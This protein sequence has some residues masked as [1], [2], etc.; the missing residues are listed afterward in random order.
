MTI[1]R[2]THQLLCTT[3]IGSLPA[4]QAPDVGR[5]VQQPKRKKS[6]KYMSL[7]PRMMF[8]GALAATVAEAAF[9]AHDFAGDSTH[10]ATNIDRRLFDALTAAPEDLQPY[11]EHIAPSSGI[12]FID[13]AVEDIDLLIAE[14]GPDIA[15]Y[16]LD[17]NTDGVEQIAA[18]L[19]DRSDVSAIHI[20]SHGRSGT[21]DL[22]SAKLT[23]VSMASGH[24]DEMAIIRGALAENADI[25]I[26]GCDFGAGTRGRDALQAFADVTGADVAASEDLTGAADLGGDWILEDQVGSIEARVLAGMEWS[27]TLSVGNSGPWTTT[28]L[29]TTNTTQ[30]VTATVAFSAVSAQSS[31]VIAGNETFNT[32]TFFAN[33]AD[34]DPSLRFTFTWDTTPEAAT[35]TT[36]PQAVTDGGTATMTITFSQ[37]VT[38]PIINLDRLGG[39][40]SFDPN[41]S[42]A[43]DEVAV[44]NSALFTLTTPGA[45]LTDL[46]VPTNIGHFIVTS[47]TIQRNVESMTYTTTPQ[48][49]AGTSNLVNTAAGSVRVNGTFTSLTFVLS[50]IGPEGGGSDGIEIGLAFDA[51]PVAQND[52]FTMNE[53]ATLTGNLYANNGAGVDADPT[54]DVMTTILVNG[55]AFTVGIPILL[56][57]GSLTITNATTGAFT[58]T[59]NANYVGGQTFTYTI[60]DA[61]GGTDTATA[62]IVV[63]AETDG[64]GIADATDI[65][66]DNDGILDSVEGVA[67]LTAANPTNPNIWWDNDVQI[68]PGAVEQNNIPAFISS[69]TV[70]SFGS[71]ITVTENLDQLNIAGNTATTLADA[72]SGNDYVEFSFTSSATANGYMNSWETFRI[73]GQPYIG[74]N[75]GVMVNGTLVSD[76]AMPTATTNFVE[77]QFNIVPQFEIHPS[78]TYTMRFY[79]YGGVAGRLDSL[80]LN[81]SAARDTDSDG[82]F[83]HLDLDSDNDS[84]SDL[85]ES[86]GGIGDALSDTNL[87][88]TTSLAEAVAAGATGDG[89][90]DNDGLMDIFDANT[91]STTAAASLGNTPLN[92]DGDIRQNYLDLDSDGDGIADTV[93]ARLT[94]GYVANDGN[95]SNDDA[96][97][98]GVINMFD[99]STGFGGTFST[100]V[101]TDG[102][103]TADYLDTNSDNDIFLDSVE[104][105]LSTVTTD[106]N[107]DGIRDSVG[108]SYSDPDGLVN[109]PQTALANA[110]GTTVDVDYRRL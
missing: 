34:A 79:I 50:G 73:I 92:T 13:G 1:G 95:V 2:L 63:L 11:I 90:I 48:A 49:E 40:S 18:I 33:A 6:N 105:G 76:T 85:S 39:Q 7:E 29:S 69:G 30:G 106:A 16:V 15:I 70:V 52:A 10:D 102:T 23:E 38:N 55:A 78:T 21:L 101:N 46:A 54:A 72:I 8:D 74:G 91:L 43:G 94:V 4:L 87:N 98:D 96:D 35:S 81:F 107:G 24:A 88:G 44:G 58:F 25:L 108:A 3:N 51:P 64:D 56:P 27:H 28:G 110:V 86:T 32:G 62:G 61:N 20:I 37:A 80:G 68:F 60:A 36:L 12:A 99:S 47:T 100:P 83:D 42:I 26:Y 59:P 5:S 65:D 109:N 77:T 104:S 14:M 93:E 71:G 66:D 84:I 31:V 41:T 19:K 57:N 9:D 53:D 97:G 67:A 89:D 75:V 103:D 22:G 82:V 45:T 17:T